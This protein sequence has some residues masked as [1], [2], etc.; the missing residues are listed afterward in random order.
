MP[1]VSILTDRPFRRISSFTTYV[2]A[3][4]GPGPRSELNHRSIHACSVAL[5]PAVRVER[6]SVRSKN[7]L[8][9]LHNS[10]AHSHS[11]ST[12]NVNTRYRCSTY[13]DKTWHCESN[14]WV[15]THTLIDTRFQIR[16]LNG[17]CI[18]YG[19]GQGATGYSCVD[20]SGQLFVADWIRHQMIEDTVH[21]DRGRISAGEAIQ[22]LQSACL[23]SVT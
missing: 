14:A 23:G 3:N 7:M 12:R 10:R 4:A 17:F 13:R 21:C 6:R 2:F 18:G 20:L 9:V 19:Q 5:D 15:K 22:V 16:E 1:C 8:V 11:I